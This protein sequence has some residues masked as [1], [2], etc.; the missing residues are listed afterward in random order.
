[1]C[2][3]RSILLTSLTSDVEDEEMK[4]RL[5]S[6]RPEVTRLGT[7]GAGG[8]LTVP[9]HALFGT[10]PL[11]ILGNSLPLHTSHLLIWPVLC[12]SPCPGGTWGIRQ[13]KVLSSTAT[14]K[15]CRARDLQLS[16]GP[17]EV[18]IIQK[19]DWEKRWSPCQARRR[20]VAGVAS[21]V[22]FC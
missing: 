8:C 16:P 15:K 13:T 1:M 21:L 7:G 20:K 9:Q 4:C 22:P 5:C 11:V 18:P 6:D 17:G 2:Q 12:P 10:E 14:L 19:S 3:V